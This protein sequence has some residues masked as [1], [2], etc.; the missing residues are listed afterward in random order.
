[1]KTKYMLFLAIVIQSGLYQISAQ[2]PITLYTPRGSSF[3]AYQ[4]PELM[5]DEEKENWSDTISIYYPQATE[6]NPPSATTTYN[7][8]SYAW[9]MSEGGP[10]C[11]IGLYSPN[12]EDIYWTDNSYTETSEPYASKISYY[13][14]DHSA[15]QTS[16]QGIYISKWGALP[17]VQ[18]ARDYGLAIYDMEY[19]KYYRLNPGINGSTSIMCDDDQRTFTSN[20]S[21]SGSTYTWSRSTSYLAYVSGSGTTSYTVEATGNPGD[22]WVG[23]QITTPSGEVATASNKNFWTGKASVQSIS[24]PSSTTPYTYNYYYANVNHSSGTTYDWMVSPTGPY[25]DPSPGEVNS[26]LVIFYTPGGYQVLARANNVCGTTTWYPKGVYVSG[27]KSMSLSPNPASEYF[28]ITLKEDPLISINGN[29]LIENSIKSDG[30]KNYKIRIY[31]NQGMLVSTLTR[32]GVTFNVPAQNV[33]DGVYIVEVD[34]G[35]TVLRA[36]LIIKH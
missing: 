30:P 31:N 19:R 32:S 10:T 25:V 8:H 1:M 24:G 12:V 11:W 28:N 13:E 9:N 7:C 16:T 27:G 17:L 23:L 35:Q 2:T 4:R 21:I 15:I 33:L 22:A 6:L 14:D 3:T 5:D 29:N 20:T 18:H 36:Q 34:D 26:C